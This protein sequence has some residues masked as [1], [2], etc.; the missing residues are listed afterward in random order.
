MQEI[1]HHTILQFTNLAFFGKNMAKVHE[2]GSI[3]TLPSVV[4][5]LIGSFMA[6]TKKGIS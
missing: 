6:T 3:D 2:F 4:S 1:S 5:I